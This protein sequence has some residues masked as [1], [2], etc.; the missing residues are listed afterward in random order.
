M[1]IFS[2]LWALE[3]LCET[4]NFAVPFK[5]RFHPHVKLEVVYYAGGPRRNRQF[6]IYGYL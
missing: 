1:Q 2:I 5:L 3:F 4:N 6:K